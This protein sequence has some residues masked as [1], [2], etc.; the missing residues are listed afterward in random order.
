MPGQNEKHK[1]ALPG[2]KHCDPKYFPPRG[3]GGEL[4]VQRL[5]FVSKT[6]GAYAVN[7]TSCSCSAAIRKNSSETSL[8]KREFDAERHAEFCCRF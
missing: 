2:A 5:I 7:M 4:E 3:G 6:R 8:R 1:R